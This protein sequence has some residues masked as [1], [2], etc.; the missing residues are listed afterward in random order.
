MGIKNEITH[1]T[2]N[3]VLGPKL[4]LIIPIGSDPN[5]ALKLEANIIN[6]KIAPTFSTGAKS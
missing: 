1:A 5:P 4:L 2:K 6:A 3:I